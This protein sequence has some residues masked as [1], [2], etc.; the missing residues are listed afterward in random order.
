[1]KHRRLFKGAACAAAVVMLAGM[2]ACGDKPSTTDP[3]TT[4]Q[5]TAELNIDQMYMDLQVGNDANIDE[6][7]KQWFPE[8]TTAAA[9]ATSDILT[10]GTVTVSQIVTDDKGSPV[11]ALDGEPVT[12]MVTS[13][14]TDSTDVFA[15][16]GNTVATNSNL[17]GMQD[18]PA[19]WLDIRRQKDY[20]FDGKMIKLTFK[21][22]D[23]AADGAV[24][25]LD[26]TS[27]D[28]TSWGNSDSAMPVALE[29]QIIAGSVKVG[30][31]PQATTGA[32]NG[33]GLYFD[34]VA[35]KPGETVTVNLNVVNNPG[36]V[37]FILN[38]QYDADILEFIGSDYGDDFNAVRTQK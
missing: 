37:V 2:T 29:P 35:G 28:M 14:V 33:M 6:A 19:R 7:L 4:A 17:K 11:T 24:A 34:N 5:T 12:T 15:E 16:P 27:T 8:L 20:V 30:S 36:F 21:I 26:V 22:K 32:F 25:K 38:L 9:A 3:D 13:F 18:L 1:M 23:T 10:T 31:T